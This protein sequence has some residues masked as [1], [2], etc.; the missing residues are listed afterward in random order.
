MCVKAIIIPYDILSLGDGFGT[1][2]EL[3]HYTRDA[4]LFLWLFWT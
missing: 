4:I 1:Q 3:Y 2:A